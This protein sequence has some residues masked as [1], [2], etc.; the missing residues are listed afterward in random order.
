[1]QGEVGDDTLY[2]DWQAGNMSAFDALYAR[3]R[4]S[5]Y[6]FL[7]RR[8]HDRAAAEDIFHDCWLR[9]IRQPQ[10]FDAG[11]F[12][13]W[14]FTVARNLSTDRFRQ[15]RRHADEPLADVN[16]A[17]DSCSPQQ[18]AEDRDCIELMKQGIA[19][20]PLEQRDAFLLKE[21]GGLAL[22]QLAQVMHTGRETI[23][24]RLRYAMQRLR[25]LLEDCL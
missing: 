23:K 12:R 8:G 21:E 17:G 14:L 7:L 6:L 13:A 20:L 25:S 2:A 16:A 19:A 22:E 15:Q 9:L 11:N 4:Q 18:S 24:S 3:Y 5:L 10:A 1:M